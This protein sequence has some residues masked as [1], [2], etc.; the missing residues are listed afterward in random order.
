MRK[1]RW[2]VPCCTTKAA[3]SL[4]AIPYLHTVLS[5]EAVER[6]QHVLIKR[7][8][9]GDWTLEA[10]PNDYFVMSKFCSSFL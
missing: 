1:F 5:Y 2:E 8:A 7:Y 3:T 9:K 6:C 10:L 4:H